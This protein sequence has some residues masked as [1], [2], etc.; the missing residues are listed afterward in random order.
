MLK[1]ILIPVAALAI[2]VTSASAFTGT[3]F[4][5]NLNV[6]LADSQK[7]ALETAHDIR[8][9]AREKAQQVLEDAG[10]DDAKMREIHDAMRDAREAS[11]KAIETAVTNNDYAAFTTAVAN[12]PLADTID[13]E[14]EFAKFVEAHALREAGDHDGARAILEELGMPTPPGDEMGGPG[15]HHGGRGF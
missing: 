9:E 13:T 14:A 15:G 8:E 6:D 2:T 1:Q 12:T 4:L 10:I 3:G 5:N 11:Y 7:T